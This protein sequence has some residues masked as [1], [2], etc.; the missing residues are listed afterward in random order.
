[1]DLDIFELKESRILNISLR[2]PDDK[3]FWKRQTHNGF[4]LVSELLFDILE[5]IHPTFFINISL[6]SDIYEELGIYS[7]I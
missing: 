2:R 6:F 5:N 7:Y 3:I 4:C 1:M